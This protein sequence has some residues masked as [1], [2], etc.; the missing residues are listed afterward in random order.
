MCNI[1]LTSKT[2][3]SLRDLGGFFEIEMAAHFGKLYDASPSSNAEST[4][5]NLEF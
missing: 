4:S 5:N 2:G 3:K 1:N